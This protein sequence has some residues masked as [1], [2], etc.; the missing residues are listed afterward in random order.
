MES[1][2]TREIFETAFADGYM[3]VE[4]LYYKGGDFP[5]SYYVLS[6]KGR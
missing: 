6:G 5:R 4:F 1:L 2:H 3:V